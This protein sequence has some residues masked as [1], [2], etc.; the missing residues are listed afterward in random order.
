MERG[1][2]DFGE[3]T[4]LGLERLIWEVFASCPPAPE[5]PARFD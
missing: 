3:E 5:E 4:F 2:R 1:V